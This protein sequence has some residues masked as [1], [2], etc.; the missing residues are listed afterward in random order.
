MEGIEA[1]NSVKAN[2]ATITKCCGY[3]YYYLELRKERLRQK[4]LM[5][6]KLRLQNTLMLNFMQEEEERLLDTLSTVS[7]IF[8]PT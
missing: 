8:I 3:Y 7:T 2:G 4:S 6:G 5:P 1:R